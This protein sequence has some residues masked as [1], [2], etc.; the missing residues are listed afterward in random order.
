MGRDVVDRYRLEPEGL[1]RWLAVHDSDEALD[2]LKRRAAT[3]P[4]SVP[5]TLAAW[6]RSATRFVLVR[7]VLAG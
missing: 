6:T 4:T 3:L 2:L 5:E 1:R 7:G